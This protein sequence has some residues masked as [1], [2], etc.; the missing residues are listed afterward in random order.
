[1]LRNAFD[2]VA[3]ETTVAAINTKTPALVSGRVPVDGSGVTQPVSFTWAGLTDAQLRAT[4]VAV[5]FTWS[6]LTDGQ[7]RASPVSVSFATPQAVTVSSLPLPTG[8]ATETTLAAVNTKT[9]ALVS[10]R[11][12][13]DGSGVTQPVSFTWSGLTDGQLRATPVPVSFATAQPVTVASLPLPAGAATEATLSTVNGKLPA[14][15]SGRVPVDG[16]G[17]TQPVSFAWAGLTDA[18]LRAT[19]VPVNQAGVSATGNITALNGNVALALNGATGFAIDLRGTFTATVTFQGTIDGTNWFTVAVIP[20]GS[21]VNIA[22]VTTATAAGAWVGN[23]N[24]MVQVRAI[25]T[26]FT[27]GT[28]NVT[29]RAMQAAGV[30]TNVPAGATTQTVTISG[31]P[32]VSISGTPVLGA[33]AARVGFV[34]GSGIWFDDTSTALASG[35]TFTATARDMF[36]VAAGVAFNSASS[37]AQEFRG[38]A[39]SDVAGTLRLEVSRDNI[40]YR[41]LRT[42]ATTQDAGGVHQAQFSW[43]PTTRFAR[44]SFVNGATAQ[45]HFML[46]TTIMAA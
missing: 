7:L 2:L 41:I 21:G 23:G 31:T 8:A 5:S 35:A 46:Q 6:G 20:A 45:G 44:Y 25:A 11:V 12:P 27:S 30:V 28:I 19:P 26:A 3:T 40:T 17:V 22:S 39:T 29:L 36:A 38:L 14:L 43:P 9:P 16:S 13:V 37:Y 15:V 32:A 24:G 18:Q 42:I 10:G 1:M 34:A 33:S 4:P